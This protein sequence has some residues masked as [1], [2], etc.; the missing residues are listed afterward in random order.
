M[1]FKKFSVSRNDLAENTLVYQVWANFG[2]VLLAT[3]IFS[4]F[5]F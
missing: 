1:N 4:Y 5:Q 2:V 3:Q